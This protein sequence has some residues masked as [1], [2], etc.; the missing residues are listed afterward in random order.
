MPPRKMTSVASP[1]TLGP[2]TTKTTLVTPS[3]T[4][5]ITRDPSGLSRR[6]SR[7]TEGQKLIG[8]SAG[9]PIWP[10]GPRP[11]PPWGRKFE[12]SRFPTSHQ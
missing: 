9:M 5:A 3:A 1:R 6:K 12:S 11:K 7:R 8:F 10:Q 4:T 2:I